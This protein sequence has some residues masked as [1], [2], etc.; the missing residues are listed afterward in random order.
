MKVL[1]TGVTALHCVEDFYLRQQLK[2]VP[3][4]LALV[5]ILRELGHTVEQRP[6]T[7]GEDLDGYD[8]VITY[9]CGT[10][11]FVPLHTPGALWTLKRPDTLVAFD[12]WQTDRTIQDGTFKAAAKWKPNFAKQMQGM[13]AQ[14]EELDELHYDWCNNRRV[15]APMFS[16]GNMDLLFAKSRRRG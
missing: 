15:L 2:V 8:K 14:R 3:S 12:D 13:E 6:V 9:L 7:W 10:D 16:N 4:E 5:R 11:S 1:V